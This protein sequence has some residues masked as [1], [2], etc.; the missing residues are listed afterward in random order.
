MVEEKLLSGSPSGPL[1][2]LS[3]E[4]WDSEGLF[5]LGTWEPGSHPCGPGLGEEMEAL[6]EAEA[7]SQIS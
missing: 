6:R 5:I 4:L 1:Q 7:F 3:A 2:L